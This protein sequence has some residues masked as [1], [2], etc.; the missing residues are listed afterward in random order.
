ML[1][2]LLLIRNTRSTHKKRVSCRARV[3]YH[4]TF[5]LCREDDHNRRSEPQRS[6]YCPL[7]YTLT[8]D[9]APSLI[10]TAN[11]RDRSIRSY[12]D[13]LVKEV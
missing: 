12:P 4:A 8:P 9:I 10:L 13:R 2:A 1:L 5:E 3:T 11:K 6:L 7:T